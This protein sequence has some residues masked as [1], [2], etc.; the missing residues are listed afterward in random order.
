MPTRGRGPVLHPEPQTPGE[1]LGATAG[2]PAILEPYWLGFTTWIVRRLE[3]RWR[4][5]VV[6]E[7]VARAVF[8]VGKALV[9]ARHGRPEELPERIDALAY[10]VDVAQSAGRLR[11]P[12]L[13]R[14]RRALSVLR[15]R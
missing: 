1:P 14:V 6:D 9:A 8:A 12:E 3:R 4:R 15:Q 10:A 13:E 2:V 7:E 5:S 11:G